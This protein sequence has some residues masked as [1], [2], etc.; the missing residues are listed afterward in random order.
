MMEFLS[1]YYVVMLVTINLYNCLPNDIL[2]NKF[3]KIVKQK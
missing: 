3:C 1:Y 2:K